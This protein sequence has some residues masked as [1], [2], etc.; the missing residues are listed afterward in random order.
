MGNGVSLL[1][2]TKEQIAAYISTI[3]LL[4][5]YASLIIEHDIYGIFLE[6]TS[7]EDLRDLLDH[8][9]V[10]NP[11]YKVKLRRELLK[12][13]KMQLVIFQNLQINQSM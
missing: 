12:L 2:L 9:G 4:S 6:A 7:E 8:W 3:P 5:S 1:I 13:K 11:I 10:T